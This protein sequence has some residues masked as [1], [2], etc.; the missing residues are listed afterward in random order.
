M[1]WELTCLF[2]TLTG[3]GV[4]ILDLQFTRPGNF[5]CQVPCRPPFFSNYLNHI[6]DPHFIVVKGCGYKVNG[7]LDCGLKIYFFRYSPRE[8]FQ[9]ICCLCVVVTHM[10][11]ISL[12]GIMYWKLCKLLGS[13]QSMPSAYSRCIK[14][15]SWMSEWFM[16][17]VLCSREY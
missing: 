8:N 6:C 17:I 7:L 1:L 12:S 5:M 16:N 11:R 13:R 14:Q 15:L 4:Y 10:S 9:L 2:I 3:L